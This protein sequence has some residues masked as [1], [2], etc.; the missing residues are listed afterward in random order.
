MPTKL[1]QVAGPI[2]GPFDNAGHDLVN[3][4]IL[5]QEVMKRESKGRCGECNGQLGDQVMGDFG[6]ELYSTH[7]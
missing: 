7:R 2:P 6:F 4:I 5:L 1:F 3:H